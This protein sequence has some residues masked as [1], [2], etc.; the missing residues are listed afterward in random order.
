MSLLYRTSSDVTKHLNRASVRKHSGIHTVTPAMRALQP[1]ETAK[2]P[3][4]FGKLI[5][6]PEAGEK[7]TAYKPI[8]G[9]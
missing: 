1:Q 6:G 3:S 4:P 2:K 7:P 9:L 8:L 5:L